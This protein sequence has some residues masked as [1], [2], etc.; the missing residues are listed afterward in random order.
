MNNTRD[1]LGL[2]TPIEYFQS[3]K[4]NDIYDV[5]PFVAPEVLKGQSYTFASDIY[6]FS[7]IMWEYISEVPPFDNEAY[8]FQLSL[9]ICKDE[10]S[11]YTFVLE[12]ADGNSLNS[13]LDKYFNKLDWNEKFKLAFQL[14]SAVSYL[15][16][17]NIIHCN[18]NTLNIF[19]HQKNIKLS[20]LGLSKKINRKSKMIG[21]YIDPK[22]L[23]DQN[24]LL[25]KKSDV[26]SIG[27]LMKQISNGYKPDYNENKIINENLYIQEEREEITKYIR[28]YTDCLNYEPDERP[29]TQKIVKILDHLN[30]FKSDIKHSKNIVIHNDSAKITDFGI[31]KNMNN[32]TSSHIVNF[33][34]IPYIDPKRLFDDKFQ[35]I[36][37]SDIYSFGVLMWE[38]SSGIPPFK[39]IIGEKLELTLDLIKG[40]REATI[41]NTP[42]DYEKLYKQCWDSEPEKRP[43]IKIILVKIKKFIIENLYQ[44]CLDSNPEKKPTIIEILEVSK[45]MGLLGLPFEELFQKYFAEIEE[46]SVN[47][48]NI[49]AEGNF[50]SIPEMQTDESEFDNIQ[51]K[52]YYDL[53]LP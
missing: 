40:K 53:C 9:D 14:A 38:I 35:Y 7:M 18:L 5:L 28:L 6:S 11:R 1:D 26:Y 17:I 21:S 25:N 31:S 44:S 20:N 33:G 16:E 4:N 43:T 12:Y 46:I 50:N 13:Y 42:E 48:N 24:Y 52:T 47:D 45:T 34:R 32:D 15:H 41:K 36:K 49:S 10:Y 2:C 3:S 30:S 23:N 51:S 39:D 19:I 37:A 27:I 29:N 8:D 22:S